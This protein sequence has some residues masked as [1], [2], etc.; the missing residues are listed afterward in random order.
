[1]TIE[2]TVPTTPGNKRVTRLS[3]IIL[4][5]LLHYASAALPPASMGLRQR[6][7]VGRGRYEAGPSKNQ[8]ARWLPRVL[9][10]LR[11][12]ASK[13][14]ASS[15]SSASWLQLES[16][17]RKLR[18]TCRVLNL[19]YELPLDPDTLLNIVL[20]WIRS[21]LKGPTI[22]CYMGRINTLHQIQG[23]TPPDRDPL[24]DRLVQGWENIQPESAKRLAVTPQVLRLI[25]SKMEESS[26]PP[27]RRSLFWCTVS[28]LFAGSLRSGEVLPDKVGSFRPD[29]TLMPSDL[30]ITT[31]QVG[32]EPVSFIKLAIRSPKER[33][34][35]DRNTWVEIFEVN[36]RIP[37]LVSLTYLDQ[38]VLLP[39]AG[40]PGLPVGLQPEPTPGPA[41]DEKK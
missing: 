36:L 1:M 21:G 37:P 2:Y 12:T 13:V 11:G 22:K 14:I 8:T 26:W 32:G 10:N 35:C 5:A 31:T 24:I 25:K 33:K 39:G 18:A 29:S 6:M 16:V 3:L 17:G 34:G 9:P 4:L 15:L 40:S 28:L 7:K 30:A 20:E 27:S 38:H 41:S 23:H 19:T